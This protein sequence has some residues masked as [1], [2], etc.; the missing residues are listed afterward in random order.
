MLGRAFKSGNSLAVH[1]ARTGRGRRPGDVEIERVG[2]TLVIRPVKTRSLD[3]VL[4]V[5]AAFPA[6][7]METRQFHEEGE[8]SGQKRGRNEIHARHQHLH[9]P[10]AAPA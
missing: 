6:D 9:P 1:P 2:E 7:F 10:D 8:R 4:K 3:G 5:F